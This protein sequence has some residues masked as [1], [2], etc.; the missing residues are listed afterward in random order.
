ME[1]AKSSER[2]SMPHKTLGGHIYDLC[3]AIRIC[4][5]KGLRS[6]CLILTYAT[7]DILAWLNR[8]E[9]HKD[10]THSDFEEWVNQYL[11]ANSNLACTATDLYGARCG[12]LH[13]YSAGSRL[14]R[15][16]EAVELWYSWNAG[17]EKDL[18]DKINELGVNIKTI[19]MEKLFAALKAGI[20]Q[21]LDDVRANERWNKVVEERARL[22]FVDSTRASLRQ[23][24]S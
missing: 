10:V 24:T 13:S 12:L 17:Q 19:Q 7:I 4:Y 6:S 18:Q 8:D 2:S 22:F 15:K 21:F 1:K 20:K 5:D 23:P 16:G 14:S 11:L 9:A 3:S